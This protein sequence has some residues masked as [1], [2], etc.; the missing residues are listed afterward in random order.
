[1]EEQLKNTSLGEVIEQNQTPPVVIDKEVPYVP[2]EE[3]FNT[4]EYDAYIDTADVNEILNLDAFESDIN[5][6]GVA[7]MANLG[8]AQPGLATDTFNPVLQ[9][10]PP[11]LGAPNSFNRGI[12]DAFNKAERDASIPDAPGTIQVDPIVSNIRQ[13]NFLRYYNHPEYANLGFS[14]F[15]NTEQYYNT[16][17]TVWDDYSRMWGQFSGL[18]GTGFMSG[19]R[20]IG[21]AFSGNLFAPDYESA[22]EFEDAM[23]IGNSS[24]EGKMA[25]TN[26]L[27]LNSGYTFGIIASV[28]VEE[29][30]MAIGAGITAAPTGGASVVGFG[31]KTAQ[32]VGRVASAVSNTFSLGR[33]AKYTRDL[34]R[35]MNNVERAKD[36]YNA[37]KGVTNF[38]TKMFFPETVAAIRSFKTAQNG[39]QNLTNMAKTARTFGGFY[40]DARSLNYALAES[41][42]ESGL[43]YNERI[44]Q[45][46]ATQV[47]KNNGGNVTAEQMQGIEENAQ[48]AGFN[49]LVRN[50]P[51]IFLSNQIVLGNAFGGFSKSFARMANDQV[52]GIGRRIIQKTKSVGADGKL[53]KDVFA[54]AGGGLKG[55]LK[56]TKSLG[57][58]GNAK[59]LLSASVRYFAANL[60]EGLQEVSQEAISHGT[61]HYY[62]AVFKDPLSGGVDL[63]HQSVNS[64]M[65]SQMNSQGLDV[66]MSGFL[67]GGVVSGPQKLFFQGLPATYNFFKGKGAFGAEGAAV[68]KEQKENKKAYVDAVVSAYNKTWN[69][70]VD[71]PGSMF[72]PQKLNFLIQKEVAADKKISA[73][74]NDVFGF[75]DATDFGKFQQIYTVLSTGGAAA[76]E[77]QLKSYRNL[78]DEDLSNAFPSDKKD[79]K[80]GKLRERFQTMITQIGNTEDVFEQTKDKFP[81]PFD[82]TQ[83]K[84]GTREYQAEVIKQQS[85]EHV[86]YLY[87][88]TKD[89]FDR[90]I[91]RSNSIYEGLA[92]DPIF[93][94]MA[95]SDL[96][97]LLDPDSIENELRLLQIEIDGLN[98]DKKANK[99]LISEK[100][101]KHNKLEEIMKVL[102]DPKNQASDGSYDRRSM[103]ALQRVFTSYVKSLAN[104]NNSFVS[105]ENIDEALK[106]MVDYKAL[107]GRAKVY[108]KAIEYLSNPEKFNDVLQRQYE[109]HDAAF[110]NIKTN[111]KE[112]IENYLETNEKNELL[113]Q[114]SS[115]EGF[116]VIPDPAEAKMFL[117]T[118]NI[119]F[120]RTFYIEQL[121]QITKANNPILFDI[122]EN[123]K[124]VYSE[125]QTKKTEEPVTKTD[126][127]VNKKNRDEV[128]DLLKSVGINKDTPA[129]VSKKYEE[130]LVKLY[131]KYSAEQTNKNELPIKFD[132][133]VNGEQ[134]ENFRNAFNALK[135]IW[136]ANDLLINPNKPLTEKEI[137]NDNTFIKWLL[138]EDGLTNDKVNAILI[139]LEIPLSDVTGQIEKMGE[140]G[141]AFQGSLTI[142]VVVPGVK[143]SITEE[144]SIDRDGQKSFLYKIIDSKTKEEVEDSLVTPYGSEYNAFLNIAEA[145]TIL[146]NLEQDLGDSEAFI[147]DDTELSY[148]TLVYRNGT[149]Y[150][151]LSKSNAI[152]KGKNLTLI[153]SDKIKLSFKDKKEFLISVPKGGFADFYSLQEL[154]FTKL[155]A[156]VSRLDV[157]EMITPYPYTNSDESK[158]LADE[159]Y[160]AILSVLSIEDIAKLDLIIA[161]DPNAGI[162]KGKYGFKVGQEKNP[163]INKIHSKY[164]IGLS[165]NDEDIRAKINAILE[166]RGL[167]KSAS[168]SGIFAFINVDSFSFTDNN[169]NS[170]EPSSFTEDDIS[171]LIRLP[172]YLSSKLSP[173]EILALT[174]KNFATNKALVNALDAFFSLDSEVAWS[175]IPGNVTIIPV[176]KLPNDINLN[177][178]LGLTKYDNSSTRSLND[179][180]YSTVDNA[181]NYLIYKLEQKGGLRTMSAETNLTGQKRRELIDNTEAALKSQGI[182]DTLQGGTDAYKAVVLLPNG[183]YALVNLKSKSQDLETLFVD[184]IN[185]AQLVIGQQPKT[186]DGLAKGSKELNDLRVWNEELRSRLWISATPGYNVSL[187]VSPWGKIELQLNK[188]K[189]AGGTRIATV[190]LDKKSILDTDLTIEAKTKNLL[191]L[192][193]DSPKVQ[194]TGVTLKAKNFRVSFA[195]DATIEQLLANTSTNVVKEVNYAGGISLSASSSSIQAAN[196]ANQVAAPITDDYAVVS[197]E[198]DSYV[199]TAENTDNSILDISNEE[200]ILLQQN[201][202]KNIPP[203]F[204]QH[205]ANKII[206]QGKEQLT[207]RELIVYNSQTISVAALISMSP[208]MPTVD[209]A[210]PVVR[211]PLADVKLKIKL[212]KTELQKGKKGRNKLKALSDS[213]EFQDLLEKKD[214]LSNEA[215]KILAAM[216]TQDIQDINIFISWAAD[217]LPEFITIQDIALLGDNLKAGGVRVGAFVLDLNDIA[218]GRSVSGTLYTGAASPYRYHEAFHGVFRMLLTDEEMI[219]YLS[220]AEKEVK[221]KLRAEGKNFKKELEKFR[222]SSDTYSNMSLDRLKQEYY[223]E[224]L[225]DEFEKFKLNPQNSNASSEIKSLFTK[226]LEW[227]KSVF[228]SYNSRELQTLFENIDSGKYT[229]ASLVKNYFTNM[230]DAGGVITANAIIP[231]NEKEEQS[232]IINSE[233]EIS[234]KTRVGFLYLDSVIAEPL[235]ASIAAMYLQRVANNVDPTI[236]RSYILENLMY[237]F[238]DLYD[239]SERINENKS[240][241]QKAIMD[242][243]SLAI[244][245]YPE[246][247]KNQVYDYLNVIDGQVEEEEYNNEYFEDKVGLRG[248]D[249]WNTDASMV[250]GINSTPK[251]IR[252]YIAS[253]T[254]AE[255]DFFGNTELIDGEPLII[256]VNFSEVYN[257][258]LKSVKNIENPRAMLQNMYFFGLQNLETGAVVSRFLSDIGVSEESLLMDSALPLELKNPQLFQAFTKAFENFRVDYLFTQRDTMGNVL[259]YSAAQRDDINSQIDRW[260]QAWTQAEK[261]LASDEA[262]KNKLEQLLDDF[263]NELSINQKEIKDDELTIS[264]QKYAEDIFNLTGIKL[265]S[266]FVSFSMIVNR[267]LDYLTPKQKALLNAN[268]GESGILRSDISEMLGLIQTSSDIFSEGDSGMNSRLRRLAI[269]NAPF[270]ET[271][272]LSVFKNAEG[273]LVY[274]HQKPTYHLKEVQKLNDV[275]YLE[276]LKKNNPYLENNY[277]LNSEAFIQLSADHRQRILRIAGSAVGQINETEEDIN[278]NISGVSA[279]STYGNFTP[280]EFA[281]SL[282]NSY[283]SL[284]NTKSGKV[285]YVEYYNQATERD[286][287]VALSPSLLRVLEAS[288]T[289]DLM[290]M[291]IVKAVEQDR[292]T[293]DIVLTDE[294]INIFATSIETE[295]DRIRRESNDETK[296]KRDIVGYNMEEYDENTG[297][298]ILGRAYQLHNSTLLLDPTIKKQL[299]EI[300]SREDAKSLKEALLEL[301]ISP[302]DFNLN[303]RSILE[304]QYDEFVNELSDLNI[305]SEISRSIKDGL[306]D[307]GKFSDSATMLNLVSLDTG[308]WVS[309]DYNLK[310]IFFN[311]WV[312]TK[313]INEILLG[314]Q[315]ITLKNGVDAIKRAK[316]QNA[317]TI[318]AYSAITAPKLGVMHP[319]D[320]IAAYPFEE[321][322]GTSSLTGEDI[323]EADAILYYTIK[324][325]RYSEFGFGTLTP[326]QADLLDRLQAGE[327]ITEEEIF[328]ENGYVA[329]DN[330]LNSRKL[331]YADGTTFIKMSAFP[332]IPQFTSNNITPKA[333]PGEMQLPAVWVA[334]P[335]RAVLHNLR[336]KLERQE[337][338][339]DVIAIAAPLSAFK[340]LKQDV[341]GLSDLENERPFTNESTILSAKNLGLQVVQP[342]NK[343][344]IIDPT[345]IKNIITSEQK[346]DVFVKALNMTVGQIKTEYNKATSARVVLKFKNKRNLIFTFDSAMDEIKIS[347]ASG[348]I[349]PNLLAFLKYAQSG[350]KASQASS[351]LLEFFSDKNGEQQ[352]DLN[353]PITVNKFES[354]FLSYLS[355]GTLAEKL[356]GHS[357]ALVSDFGNYV[358]R[359]VYSFDEN[360][361]PE[362]SEIIRQKN[363][364]RYESKRYTI[365]EPSGYDADAQPSWKGY[366]VP[367][368]GIVILDRLRT[369]VKEFDSQGVFTGERHTEGLMPAHFKEVMSL[370]ENT[371]Q[372]IPEVISKM[373]AIRI[374]SQDNHS[375]MNVK[376]VDFLPAV[377]GSV[378]M[379]AKELIEISGADFDIDKVY[380]QIKE[381]YV[382]NNKFYEYGKATTEKDAYLSY[383]TYI[384][385]K[386]NKK[387]SIYNEALASSAAEIDNSVD[388]IEYKKAIEDGLSK[389]SVMSL[390]VLGLPI[391]KKDY[392]LYRAKHGEPYEAPYNNN[393]LDYK[394][395]LM[396]NT[397][398]TESIDGNPAISYTPASLDILNDL[399]SELSNDLSGSAY[400]RERSREDNID[401]DN[402]LG[403]IKAFKANKG[404]AIGA[405]V[406]PN[407][408]LSLLTEYEVDIKPDGPDIVINGIRFNTFKHFREQLENGELGNRKQDIISSLITM[409]TD[410]A[411]ERLVAKLGLN[412]EALALVANLTGLG[413]PIRTSILLINNPEIQSIYNQA[414]NKKEK[415]DPGVETLTRNKINEIVEKLKGTNEPDSKLDIP[416]VTDELLFS[417]LD[418]EISDLELLSILNTF[419]ESVKVARFTANM[420]SIS[421][422]TSGLGKDIAALNYKK[423]QI[424]KLF[425]KK[426]M[427]DLSPIYKGKTW[428][429]TYLDIFNQVYDQLLPATFLSASPQ[430]TDIMASVLSSIDVDNMEFTSETQS[431]ISR[432]LLSY[433]TIKAYQ[434]NNGNGT[435]ASVADLNNNFIYPS[436]QESI[437][438]LIDNL[439]ETEVGKNN[440]FLDVF[441]ISTP[442]SDKNNKTGLNLIESNTYRSL[443]GQQKIDLQTSFAKIY[444]SL[445]TRNAALS[446]INYMMV[447]DGLQLAYGTLLD[448]ISPFTMS[449]YLDHIATANEALRD[450]S[451][452][453]MNSAFGVTFNEMKE[454]FIKGYLVSNVN[455]SL[456]MT[457]SKGFEQSLPKGVTIKDG[458][459]SIDYDKSSRS[460]G[461]EFLR[462][463]TSEIGIAGEYVSYKTYMRDDILNDTDIK[464]TDEIGVYIEVDTRGSNQQNGIGFMFGERPTY[465]E[466][467]KYSKINQEDPNIDNLD[468]DQMNL[469]NFHA[470]IEAQMQ[471]SED[472]NVVVGTPADGGTKVIF[473]GG[474]IVPAKT[475]QPSEYANKLKVISERRSMASKSDLQ[476][477]Q[478]IKDIRVDKSQPKTITPNT[479]DNKLA[480]IMLYGKTYDAL[481]E[482]DLPEE[483]NEAKTL[484]Y[485]ILNDL[486]FDINEIVEFA[487]VMTPEYANAL[488]TNEN[489]VKKFFENDIFEQVEQTS[490][491][492]LNTEDFNAGIE[493]SNIELEGAAELQAELL[494]N[495]NDSL[496]NDL[497]DPVNPVLAEFWDKEIENNPERKAKLDAAGIGTYS[498]MLA[499][500]NNRY[501]NY[502]SFMRANFTEEQMEEVEGSD[503]EMYIEM[504]YCII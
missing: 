166:L 139:K 86:R 69:Q 20:S 124:Y 161:L 28:A 54:D 131:K 315:A 144:V 475:Q 454:E 431:K 231:Y 305:Q 214:S 278:N 3:V 442:S 367:A 113:N 464:T 203:A 328:G 35:S 410:N 443:N 37:S 118:G 496:I 62:D 316:S 160:K 233:G 180:D 10:N 135:A 467:R 365:T 228:S 327:E 317:A 351:N 449:A 398:V 79:I 72:D 311:D 71:D 7:A 253:T 262:V 224:Y 300:A 470:S 64:A 14:P 347:K 325:L 168:G 500:F 400:L 427:M 194:A 469:D 90:A 243:V 501:I 150:V 60:A 466:V 497:A 145:K 192:F 455:N 394:Y 223:E 198:E 159:R 32:N 356:P 472:I 462:V 184:V 304:A 447:K 301:Q 373:F 38:T 29:V 196:N 289:G 187:Q 285:D 55:L 61:N 368:E 183:S 465:A 1:M 26:N 70:Q 334:K 468:I 319:N 12:N 19:Y 503:E 156:S 11:S 173:Q 413:V 290:Y 241:E 364:E 371:N 295:Y 306:E 5:K 178:R 286:V 87:M 235:I 130:L 154:N 181:G 147:F 296:T 101:S 420:R 276:E 493:I 77:N 17:S 22:N 309:Q 437:N 207:A 272:G 30:V 281:L 115:I 163:Y 114:I 435:S 197:K 208:L 354:L 425:S 116:E 293:G 82:S 129:S 349:T 151:V 169:N 230:A 182:Y 117:A 48:E 399:W 499:E 474:K 92:S 407:Q 490:E 313:A 344:E 441:T 213:K 336:V 125:G 45:N 283:T 107:K 372:P 261:K 335:N 250:G 189:L 397:G 386:I 185:Q 504:I 138:S 255:T 215:N 63:Y 369:N 102:E 39:V 251:M 216:T 299:E 406:S 294:I 84:K 245:E 343:T 65:G 341:T 217:N 157:F 378:G 8:V 411:K 18:A 288:N 260:S 357:L 405:I 402:I 363:W 210:E 383:I 310:Q 432:D 291:P 238:Y 81:N 13:T 424:N 340:M 244:E 314:D 419:Y 97:V 175:S 177:M 438:D 76:F 229:N 221:A 422:L 429:S 385:S 142:K 266:Q 395:A 109:V 322:L 448:A 268:V 83:F 98:L 359:R 95:A 478:L 94:K 51:L 66:F 440:F 134:A 188:G 128:N 408:S 34:V 33:A 484:A 450:A 249:Q 41:K 284:V 481:I 280:Q 445:E 112:V 133:W 377:Y 346:D 270:D 126:A 68:I 200:F 78:S 479:T 287:K 120:L 264:S 303:L 155:P 482:E 307:I 332:L 457:F 259:M 282:I 416:S 476:N 415:F 338:E 483:A 143:F 274:A 205:I 323:E 132:K 137:L 152:I 376:M 491:E 237:D 4:P 15:A 254:S 308:K 31:A 239:S 80:N 387:G 451:D 24:R 256:P 190:R 176:S 148:G 444:G 423:D 89:G 164:E 382:K 108:D 111:F 412:K 47:A 119:E 428:Q 390:Q 348:K 360:G 495:Q 74:Q 471:D 123:L 350:L 105:K 195:R 433:I 43:V 91:E 374:P 121:G 492:T 88:F 75:I 273:N 158:Q 452:E 459:L 67:M 330:M 473:E 487:D 456:L 127:E 172:E 46:I 202:F 93:D 258:L 57:V 361:L 396:G 337:S 460:K 480:A 36:L 252:A 355:K 21:D 25:W 162:N 502:V 436:D 149:E 292:S 342:S 16:N 186:T 417:S 418:S 380:A 53:A 103:K 2:I 414:I 219:K 49:T 52:K 220:I 27:L 191:D 426:A 353:N 201:N 339:N 257:G 141:S 199:P 434:H 110:N 275:A 430:F 379:F 461:K 23:A 165:T 227:I 240:T 269:D 366:N 106:K 59:G 384:E 362:R 489:P 439:R 393:I 463:R 122:I 326:M 345:Q 265:S 267:D 498:L 263:Q 209:I 170:V 234:Y 494:N 375:T 381:W 324:G 279:R 58:K 50:A 329:N 488:T 146:G 153:P 453:K 389:K 320:A 193:N 370:I 226:I 486:L 236:T 56:R 297:E 73:Y 403:K 321:P 247:I 246:I 312:N 6:Y 222:N 42:L 391:T 404:A 358:Y 211:S 100:E 174:K 485:R 212:L 232:E 271:I 171:N 331:V 242:Q 401:I 167:E 204:L 352:Y 136:V 96:T 333:L 298:K 421:D 392:L 218:G 302:L 388:D 225:A 409:A 179:L 477:S 99:D 446:I 277:L 140:E 318:S 9:Q 85:W 248:S 458:I 44:R 206:T 104:T 40:R